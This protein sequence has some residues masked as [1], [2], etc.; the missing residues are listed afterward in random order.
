MKSFQLKYGVIAM[1][2]QTEAS[3]KAAAEISGKL[4]AKE[5]QLNVLRRTLSESH[6]AV[7]EAEIEIQEIRKKLTDMNSGASDVPGEMKVL[8]PFKQTP[9]LA[10]DYVRL[11][12]EIEIQYKILQFV[13]PLFEQAKV[14]EQ[15]STPSVVVLDYASV[16][17]R[18]A[19]PKLSLYLLM[20]FVLSTIG[21][22]LLV[23]LAEGVDRL[24]AAN[25]GQFD[26]LG[27]AVRSDWF[28]LRIGKGDVP[29][30]RDSEGM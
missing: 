28:G 9:Q 2:E 25:P 19:K 8:V 4:A 21:S 14:E 26:T 18:K 23:F 5:I 27:R 1:P 17:E 22:I 16:P 29:G 30:G 20:A 13:T 10:I 12:R 11:Y 7:R 6:A 24:R 3:I 15:R